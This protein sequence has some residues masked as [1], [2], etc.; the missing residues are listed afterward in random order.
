ML[1]QSD[2]LTCLHINVIVLSRPSSVL[3]MRRPRH[4]LQHLNMTT[5]WMLAHGRNAELLKSIPAQRTPED[6]LST[7][8][9]LMDAEDIIFRPRQPAAVIISDHPHTPTGT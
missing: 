9:L 4:R 7:V 3:S 2:D 5:G 8:Y 6:N 1:D